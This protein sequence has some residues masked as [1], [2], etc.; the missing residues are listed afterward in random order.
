MIVLDG[1]QGEGG[2]QV[3]RSALSLALITRQP[4]RLEHVRARRKPPGLKAQHLTCVV[5]AASLGDAEVE[6]A[7]LGS[8]T[9]TF[10]PRALR[11]G[12]FTFDVGTAGSMSLLLHCLAYPLA[13][14]GGGSLTLTGGSH[15]IASPSFD[16]VSRVWAPLVAGYGLSVRPTLQQAGFFP[17]GGGRLV[18]SIE[19][20]RLNVDRPLD[21]PALSRVVVRSVVAGLS[22]DIARRQ[23]D[24][25]RRALNDVGV[26]CDVEVEALPAGP[27]KGTALLV[28][29]EAGQ[30]PLGG[31]SALGER[32][33]PA[34]EV[35]RLAVRD[36]RHFL[37]GHGAVDEHAGDQLL[38]PMGLAAA[39]LL[40]RA[41]ESRFRAH[42][43]SDHLTTHAAVLEA[44]L[45]VQVR[46]VG[47]EV[48]VVPR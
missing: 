34:E 11:G 15:V 28:V 44:F 25:A 23:A 10:H 45:P 8:E 14:A 46:V 33:L 5:G 41:R 29:L 37:R 40:G 31:F 47:D 7:T 43:V 26:P 27:S 13:F 19:P 30:Q 2:G 17:E 32:R 3:L 1:S 22:L 42:V 16:Y 6:G 36:A 38:L 48:S 39:G 18:A 4:F 21:R 20:P 35:A 9:L 12:D 24:T